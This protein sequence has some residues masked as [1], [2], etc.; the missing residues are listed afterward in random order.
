MVN[1]TEKIIRQFFLAQLHVSTGPKMLEWS[2]LYDKEMDMHFR[3][4]R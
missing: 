4:Q 3:T 1:F 2:C